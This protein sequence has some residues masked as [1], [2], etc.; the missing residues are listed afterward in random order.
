MAAALLA[1]GARRREHPPRRPELLRD[2]GHGLTSQRLDEAIVTESAA[3]QISV[4]L[5]GEPTAAD[6]DKERLRS[7]LRGH[8]GHTGTQPAQLL[9][10]QVVRA[11]VAR[12]ASRCDRN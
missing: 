9:P 1:P 4:R 12:V 8:F 2:R 10:D 3:Y 11:A 5:Q 6:A 7:L